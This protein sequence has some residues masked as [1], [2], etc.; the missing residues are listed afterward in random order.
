MISTNQPHG[1]A[2][3]TSQAAWVMKIFDP[4]ITEIA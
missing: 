3:P 2:S 4:A 1:R